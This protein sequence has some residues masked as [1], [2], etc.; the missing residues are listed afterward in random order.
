MP[1]AGALSGFVRGVVALLHA[2][3]Q[4]RRQLGAPLVEGWSE[5]PVGSQDTRRRSLDEAAHV[6]GQDRGVGVGG[7]GDAEVAEHGLDVLRVLAIVLARR[8]R[9]SAT[10]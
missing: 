4:C 2:S 8:H 7:D 6:R 1:L 10:D 9:V 5:S 3:G